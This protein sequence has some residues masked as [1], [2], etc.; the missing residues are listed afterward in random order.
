VTRGFVCEERLCYG[1][2]QALERTIARLLLHAGFKNVKLVG[3]TGDRGADIV[4]MMGP[5]VWVVQSKYRMDGWVSKEAGQEAVRSMKFYGATVAVAVSN[6]GFNEEALKHREQM[7]QRGVTLN[8]W[9]GAALHRYFQKL[10]TF[11]INRKK[12][13]DYQGRAVAAAEEARSQGQIS[14][15]ILMATGLGKS[16]VAAELAANEISRNPE[17]EILVLAHTKGIVSQLEKSFWPQLSKHTSTHLW[18]DG[19][20]PSYNGGIVFATYQS[21]VSTIQ[22]GESLHKRF[23]VVIVDEAHHAPASSYSMLI[24]HL[25]P[26]FLVG[27]TATPW[28]GDGISLQQVFGKP[29]FTMGIV[30]AM[31]KGYLSPVEY[32]MLADSIDWDEVALCSKQGL[33]IKD[34]NRRLIL[35][36][37]DLAMAKR[38]S[39]AAKLIRDFRGLGFCRSI[40]HAEK[41]LPFLRAHGLEA[42][43]VHSQQTRDEIYRKLSRFQN[44]DIKFLLSVEMLNE[45][46][47][48]PE[49]N[50]IAFMRVTHSRRIFVQQLGRGLRLSPNKNKVVVLDFVADIRRYIEG[51]RI[52]TQAKNRA[53]NQEVLYFKN[54]SVISFEGAAPPGFFENYLEDVAN[55]E[56]IEDT[57]K[58]EFPDRF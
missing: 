37:R 53:E 13:R 39:D 42:A 9:G 28:R 14:A 50:F 11:C 1:P 29:V 35:P 24:E 32:S 10:E 47:D 52:N 26:N 15:L 55:L 31:Q 41:L 58:L 38:I 16:V 54:G 6:S 5:D 57:A 21:L 12:L 36:E 23:S 2:W 18:A 8:L 43:L 7:I 45:G 33:S 56:D 40:N 25:A 19:E 17:Q 20:K 44:A 34:L 27:L 30:E 4:G 49:V 22:T 51:L 48:L 3:G 46:I